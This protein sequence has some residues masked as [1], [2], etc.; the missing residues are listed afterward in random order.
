MEDF[1]L[2]ELVLLDLRGKVQNIGVSL[3]L[4]K[5]VVLFG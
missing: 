3:A 1:A 2:D 4:H 5:L